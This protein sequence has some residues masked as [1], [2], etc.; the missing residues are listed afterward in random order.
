MKKSLIIIVLAIAGFVPCYAQQDSISIAVRVAELED[1]VTAIQWNLL[2]AR[3]Q[4]RFGTA[5]TLTGILVAAIPI[6]FDVRKSQEEHYYILGG[7]AATTGL[8]IQFDAWNFIGKSGKYKRK[9]ERIK[10]NVSPYHKLRD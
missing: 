5:T 8:F 3:R 1:R 2:E 9:G 4:S 7:F 10:H 6:I